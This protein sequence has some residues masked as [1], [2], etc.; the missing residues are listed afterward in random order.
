MSPTDPGNAAASAGEGVRSSRVANA[1]ARKDEQLRLGAGGGGT[2]GEGAMGGLSGA[3]NVGEGEGEGG[4]LSGV[5]LVRAGGEE[6]RV[7]ACVLLFGPWLLKQVRCLEGDKGDLIPPSS[8]KG[9]GRA[10][11][12]APKRGRRQAGRRP[13]VVCR[14]CTQGAGVRE[15]GR[16]SR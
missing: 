10:R 16:S 4:A 11:G 14:R 7:A 3:E 12:G 6:E 9:A 1:A 2:E 8:G 13:Q 5:S 15:G